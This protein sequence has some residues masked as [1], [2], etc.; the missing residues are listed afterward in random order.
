MKHSLKLLTMV[1]GVVS[2]YSICFG[3]SKDL[4]VPVYGDLGERLTRYKIDTSDIGDVKSRIHDD[5]YFLSAYASVF[6]AERGHREI[7]PMVRA[8]YDSAMADFLSGEMHVDPYLTDYLSALFLLHDPDVVPMTK[9]LIDTLVSKLKLANDWWY[10]QDLSSAIRLLACAG[11][12]T[13]FGNLEMLVELDLADTAQFQEDP[14]YASLSDTD[15]KLLT[16]YGEKPEYRTAVFN[17]LKEYASHPKEDCRSRAELYLSRYFTDISDAREVV[18]KI[19]MSDPDLDLRIS[20]IFDL[21]SRFKD[22]AAI[23]ITQG[24]ILSSNDSDQVRQALWELQDFESPFAFAALLS[25]LQQRTQEPFRSL[26]KFRV[27]F[28]RAPLL[29]PDL[30]IAGGIDSLRAFTLECRNLK[31]IGGRGFVRELTNHLEDARR[32]LDR[33]D[34][35][36]SSRE[37]ERY[38]SEIDKEYREGNKRDNRFITAAGWKYLYMEAGYVIAKLIRL[39]LNR[40]LPLPQLL[41]SLK[42]ELKREEDMRNVGGPLLGRNLRLLLDRASGQLG[43]KDSSGAA[44]NILLFQYVVSRTSEMTDARHGRR[45]GHGFLYV[46]D[47]AY[48]KLFYRAKYILERLPGPRDVIGHYGDLDRTLRQELEKMEKAGK[49][50]R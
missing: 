26:I 41:D 47:E 28:Y 12:Y 13:Q 9:A 10:Q 45:T 2:L 23:S 37:I 30:P 19:A 11:D 16:A 32:H 1:L 25:C 22:P 46:T 4:T 39:P 33:K 42:S 24:I 8:K 35:L 14:R 31:W 21:W 40:Y 43:R 15:F 20:A 49:P 7:L 36:N 5:R 44:L 29:S 50:G 6:L 48:V 27:D 17:L 38:Q 3:Q 34:S 18:S